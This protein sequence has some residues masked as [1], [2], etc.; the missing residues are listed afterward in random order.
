M[1]GSLTFSGS[2]GASGVYDWVAEVIKELDIN[3]NDLEKIY[4][5]RKNRK[6]I[7][8]VDNLLRRLIDLDII[9]DMDL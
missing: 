9:T 6:Y 4:I 1:T 7:I 8:D 3:W 2:L 5:T